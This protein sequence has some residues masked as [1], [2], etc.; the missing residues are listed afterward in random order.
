MRRQLDFEAGGE[1]VFTADPAQQCLQSLCDYAPTVLFAL[2]DAAVH[3]LL[4]I[5]IVRCR[6]K[7]RLEA[8]VLALRH[9]LRVLE[10]QVGRPPVWLTSTESVRN[11]PCRLL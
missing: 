7:A 5:L 8:E 10:R 9:Q 2:L 4:E 6:S 3:L 11:G 1:Y